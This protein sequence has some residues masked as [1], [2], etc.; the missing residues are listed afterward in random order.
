MSRVVSPSIPRDFILKVSNRW[1]PK[2]FLQKDSETRNIIS[3]E[4]KTRLFKPK[5]VI[6]MDDLDKFIEKQ[7]D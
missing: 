5:E 1:T 6:K 7:K 3:T 2:I 4:T